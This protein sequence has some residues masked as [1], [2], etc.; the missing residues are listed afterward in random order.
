MEHIVSMHESLKGDSSAM[1][2]VREGTPGQGRKRRAERTC[3]TRLHK[4]D[5]F[6]ES[7]VSTSFTSDVTDTHTSALMA[8]TEKKRGSKYKLGGVKTSWQP[9]QR[10]VEWR[11]C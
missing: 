1:E 11:T 2:G 10:R 6:Y 3:R 7:R 4:C 9:Q 5:L 8:S